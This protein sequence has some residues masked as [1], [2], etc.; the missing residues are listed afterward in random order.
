M[1]MTVIAILVATLVSFPLGGIWFAVIFKNQ[2]LKAIGRSEPATSAKYM[3][4]PVLCNFVSIVASAILIAWFNISTVTDILLF[5]LVIGIGYFGATIV[6]A[7]I[8]PN[9]KSW[10]LYGFIN[11]PYFILNAVLS[12]VLLFYVP[13]LF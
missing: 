11:V 1:T 8:N 6:N 4:G 10:I 12:N 2:Y 3:I 5:S 7:G 13:R 9:M